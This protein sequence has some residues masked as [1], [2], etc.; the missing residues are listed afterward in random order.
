MINASPRSDR[1]SKADR[2]THPRPR[3]ASSMAPQGPETCPQGLA[4]RQIIPICLAQ[5]R[6]S[7]SWREPSQQSKAY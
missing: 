3:V 1:H 7:T 5:A 6:W 4:A 2:D